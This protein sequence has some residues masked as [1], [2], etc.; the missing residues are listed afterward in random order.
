MV[1]TGGAMAG[2]EEGSGV[3]KAKIFGQEISAPAKT[4]NI[5]ILIF[6]CAASGFGWKHHNDSMEWNQKIYDA[7]LKNT[8]AMVAMTY[9]LTLSQERREKLNL[10][11]PDEVRQMQR[12]RE[13]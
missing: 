1:T 13:Q 9:V 2:R 6:L 5:L 11:M 4:S 8:K 12:H 3:I 7:T 10:E